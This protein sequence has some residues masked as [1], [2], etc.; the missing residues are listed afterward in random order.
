MTHNLTGMK[1]LPKKV[2]SQPLKSCRLKS[3]SDKVL[4]AFEVRSS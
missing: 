1:M 3:E 2:E 4:N